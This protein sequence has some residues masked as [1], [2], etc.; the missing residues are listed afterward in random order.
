MFHHET[1][2]EMER[3]FLELLGHYVDIEPYALKEFERRVRKDFRGEGPY[4]DY[5]ATSS[6]SFSGRPQRRHTSV[7][8]PVTVFQGVPGLSTSTSNTPVTGMPVTPNGY[9]SYA[10]AAMGAYQEKLHAPAAV[11]RPGAIYARASGYLW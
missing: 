10:P 7:P 2:G 4:P 3:K 1:V 8:A 11:P 5:L 9:P 6:S